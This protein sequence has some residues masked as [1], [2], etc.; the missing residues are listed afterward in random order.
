MS[1]ANTFNI[2]TTT[3]SITSP[4]ECSSTTSTKPTFSGAAGTATGDSNTVTVRI[5]NGWSSSG[6]PVQTLTATRA[7]GSWSTTPTTA[8][9]VGTY[10][11]QATQVITSG[12]STSPAIRF[13]ISAAPK[14]SL[15]AP[16]QGTTT[17]SSRPS[18]RGAAG[19]AAGDEPTITLHIYKGTGPTGTPAQTLTA[20][21][22]KGAWTITPTKALT[23]GA[24][25]ARAS[26]KNKAGATGVS[27]PR[28]F[29][30]R[31]APGAVDT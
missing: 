24:Y 12:S 7:A 17:V 1:A 20:T 16:A 19:T 28:T 11:A 29:T 4:A 23:T 31:S 13:T 6:T 21:A 2:A 27:S 9:A 26:Q 3:V 5:Y 25:T 22:G 8:L 18:F 15:T 10:T 30:I 14:V